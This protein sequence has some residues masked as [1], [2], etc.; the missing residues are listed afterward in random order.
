MPRSGVAAGPGV[1]DFGLDAVMLNTFCPA[2]MCPLFAASGSP[3]TGDKNSHCEGEACG[4]F[5]SECQ[6]D[7][8][9]A[10]YEQ[11]VEL[12]IGLPVLQIG[13]THASK[14]RKEPSTFDCPRAS[15]CQWQTEADGSDVVG[16]LCPPRDALRMGLEMRVCAY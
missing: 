8:A 16:A 13:I 5:N 14:R 11:V 6:C 3:W 4:W 1:S 15:E 7:G 10:A 2:T 9:S 12:H